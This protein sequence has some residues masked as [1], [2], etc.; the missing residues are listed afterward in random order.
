MQQLLEIF[1]KPEMLSALAALVSAIAALTTIYMY[2][3]QGKGFVW[4]KDPSVEVIVSPNG[5]LS[6][7]VQIPILNLG[8]GNLRF[9]KMKAK[10][11]YK[12]NNSI[13]NYEI[14]MEEAY[15]P[16]GVKIITYKTSIFRDEKLKSASSLPTQIL[17]QKVEANAEMINADEMQ[18]Q[19]NKNIEEIG[20]VIFILKCTYKDGSW[21]GF[22][23]RTTAIGMLLHGLDLNY[24]SSTSRKE[25]KSLFE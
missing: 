18:M 10:K 16:P 8:L 2:R 24:L 17:V 21:F 22:G 20:D 11:I 15:F 14:D 4:T 1:K 6:V 5:N 19:I 3:K 9:L 25:L 7:A 12:K 13:E 23:T